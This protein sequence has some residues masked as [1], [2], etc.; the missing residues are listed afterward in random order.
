MPVSC[1]RCPAWTDSL[2]DVLDVVEKRWSA[3][4]GCA[5]EEDI[6]AVAV[7]FQ[8]HQSQWWVVDGRVVIPIWIVE[9][10]RY[11]FQNG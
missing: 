5:H 7:Q 1:G 6:R 4:E 11:R 3:C 10:L 9:R 2:V 8:S